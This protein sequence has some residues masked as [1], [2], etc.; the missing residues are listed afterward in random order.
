MD[1]NKI[2]AII[3]YILAIVFSW[4]GLIY[5][6]LL[7]LISSNQY[8]K[9]HGKYIAILSLAILLI[10]AVLIAIF[11]VAIFGIGLIES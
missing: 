8:L 4:G 1:S 9:K 11:G 10:G 2:L 7:Y 3:G 6:I 5:G